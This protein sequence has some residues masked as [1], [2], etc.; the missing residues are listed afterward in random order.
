[1]QFMQQQK[2][3]SNVEHQQKFFGNIDCS[4][5]VISEMESRKSPSHGATARAAAGGN[6]KQQAAHAEA[7]FV[8][9]VQEPDEGSTIS[10]SAP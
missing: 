9:F 2:F 5:N 6:T 4:S 8:F 7:N 1:M 10:Q 3:F